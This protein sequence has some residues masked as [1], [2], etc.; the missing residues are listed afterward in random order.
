MS[1]VSLD[2]KTRQ[3]LEA[4]AKSA[5]QVQDV[6]GFKQWIRQ[7]VRTVLPHG[8]FA[9]VYGRLHGV[10]V[11]LDYVVTVDYPMEH[12]MSL[13]NASGQLDTPIARQWWNKGAPV[14][15]DEDH[16]LED[17]SEAWLANFRKHGLINA[18]ANGVRDRLTCLSTYF[19]F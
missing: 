16:P 18:A 11:T 7:S 15:F 6:E 1:S 8:P 2:P 19:S 9:C 12:L 4:C 13:R 10:G 3:G 14:F 5:V 17:I